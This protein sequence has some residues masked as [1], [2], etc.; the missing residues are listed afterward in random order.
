[1]STLDLACC[2]CRCLANGDVAYRREQESGIGKFLDR[3]M[4]DAPQAVRSVADLA[5]AAIKFRV[6]AE[7][8]CERRG[9][10]CRCSRRGH[11]AVIA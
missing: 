4:A 2:P 6:S 7:S 5:A 1:M 11:T 10:A 9:P 3:R 8:R